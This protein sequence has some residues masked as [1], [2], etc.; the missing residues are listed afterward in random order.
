MLNILYSSSVVSRLASGAAVGRYE[1]D[2]QQH[3]AVI[4]LL[5]T[6]N[7]RRTE[8]ESRGVDVTTVE[9]GEEEEEYDDEYYYGEEYD[10]GMSGDYELEVPQGRNLSLSFFSQRD[11][12]HTI[13]TSRFLS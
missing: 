11:S 2:R 5:D 4:N 9:Y 13:F 6:R 3:T 1:S 12:F 8:E 10:N 7:D